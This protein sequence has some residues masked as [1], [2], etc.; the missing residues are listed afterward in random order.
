M[1]SKTITLS[2]E[3]YDRFAAA[4]NELRA[5]NERLRAVLRTLADANDWHPVD[6]QNFARETL[7]DL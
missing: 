4:M 6:M 2:H 1:T 5:E 7:K 3:E